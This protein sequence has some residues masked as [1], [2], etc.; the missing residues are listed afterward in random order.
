MA[1]LA[2]Q[3]YFIDYGGTINEDSLSSVLPSYIPPDKRQSDTSL[4]KWHSLIVKAYR[5]LFD[6]RDK[7]PSEQRV[8]TDLIHYARKKWAL[9]FSKLYDVVQVEG[10]F[11]LEGI[12]VKLGINCQEVFLMTEEGE[13]ISKIPFE[14]ISTVTGEMYVV[15]S[16]CNFLFPFTTLVYF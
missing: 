14:E 6:N 2:A 10:P 11:P 9:P 15:H 13:F 5:K 1:V 7:L 8:K 3:Q 12:R 4:R 16:I